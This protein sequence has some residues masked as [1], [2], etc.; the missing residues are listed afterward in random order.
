M[1]AGQLSIIMQ[2]SKLRTMQLYWPARR[3]VSRSP[4]STQLTSST[5][6]L[7]QHQI[8]YMSQGQNAQLLDIPFITRDSGAVTDLAIL[9]LTPALANATNISCRTTA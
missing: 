2:Y 9:A 1:R 8:S 4:K 5:T 6:I 3:A 7:P